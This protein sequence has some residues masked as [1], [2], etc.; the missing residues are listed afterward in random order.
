MGKLLFWLLVGFAVYAG[1]RWWQ[2]RQRIDQAN[3]ERPAPPTAVGEPMVR[4][5]VCGLNLPRSEALADGAR[6]FCG[7]EHRRIGG[8]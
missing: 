2:A 5:E 7:E 6:H 1:W 4:C 3:R 8:G